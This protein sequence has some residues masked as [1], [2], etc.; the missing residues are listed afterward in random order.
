MVYDLE[1]EKNLNIS[2]NDIFNLYGEKY[3]EKVFTGAT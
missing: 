2:I 3:G 1:I